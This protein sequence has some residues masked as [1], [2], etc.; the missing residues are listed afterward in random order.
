MRGPLAAL[1]VCPRCGA[2]LLGSAEDAWLL[3]LS[4]GEAHEVAAG[5]PV[6][7]PLLFAVPLGGEPGPVVPFFRFPALRIAVRALESGG[8]VV[9]DRLG[10]IRTGV[11]VARRIRGFHT[12]GDVGLEYTRRPP[13]LADGGPPSPP[14]G[15]T[16]RLADARAVLGVVLQRI[17]LDHAPAGSFSL[18]IDPGAAELWCVPALADGGHVKFP[19]CPIRYPRAALA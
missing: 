15:V 18:E 19:H 4:C 10:E 17:A 2:A 6:V 16:R 11:V 3:C 12:V 7:L 14:L 1:A 13:R 5:R 8:E 9:A